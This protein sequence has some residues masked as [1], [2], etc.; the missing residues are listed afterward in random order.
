MSAASRIYKLEDLKKIDK[1]N[2]DAIVNPE[3]FSKILYAYNIP[4]KQVCCSLLRVKNKCNAAHNDGYI[5]E[6]LDGQ[7]GVIGGECV[8]LHFSENHKINKAINSFEQVLGID[9]KLRVISKYIKDY[10][11]LFSSLE[12]AKNDVDN[13]FSV[14][15]NIYADLGR[16]NCHLLQ[17]K[18]KAAKPIINIKAYKL[19]DDDE[20]IYQATYPIGSVPS[21]NL[22]NMTVDSKSYQKRFR[23][24]KIALNGAYHLEEKLYSKIVDLEN[25]KLDSYVAELSKD[26]Q[27]IPMFIN[28]VNSLVSNVTK[29]LNSDLDMLCYLSH[30]FEDQQKAAEFNLKKQSK[31]ITAESYLRSI[32]IKFSTKFRCHRIR[33][34]S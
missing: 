34:D 22:F 23:N 18:A 2:L 4:G 3:N 10:D 17:Q 25:K 21:L 24:L 14:L 1:L 19:G 13:C 30:R 20:Y 28:E 16:Y 29:F 5:A 15:S 9:E 12:K 27:K 31:K 8:R 11:T 32:E 26:L 6:L 7:L 33:V